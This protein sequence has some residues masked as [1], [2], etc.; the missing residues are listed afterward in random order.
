MDLIAKGLGG[1]EQRWGRIGVIL[2]FSL[3]AA[4]LLSSLLN[5]RALT[6]R[7]SEPASSSSAAPNALHDR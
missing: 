1:P 3:S 7:S 6:S 5:P 4:L 2:C